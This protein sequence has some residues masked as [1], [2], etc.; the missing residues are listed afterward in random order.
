MHVKFEEALTLAKTLAKEH[1]KIMVVFKHN[2]DVEVVCQ[3]TYAALFEIRGL[4]CL[5]KVA[6]SGR[7][8]Q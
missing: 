6:P 2:G 3:D 5:A 4:E 8:I 7:I 1:N